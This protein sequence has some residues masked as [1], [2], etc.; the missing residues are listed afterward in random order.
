MLEDDND[1]HKYKFVE[2]LN[3]RVS[4]IV[5]LFTV[6]FF[7]TFIKEKSTHNDFSISY[8]HYPMPLT[9]ELEQSRDQTS[10]SLVIFFVAIAFS[11]IR[12]RKYK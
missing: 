6:N 12:K 2:V 10:N 3:T 8:K 4:H 9:T 7:K 11:L 1:N 5:P